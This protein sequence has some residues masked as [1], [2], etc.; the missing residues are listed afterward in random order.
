MLPESVNLMTPF[1]VDQQDI[2]DQLQLIDDKGIS[3]Y[4]EIEKDRRSSKN[5]HEPW[6]DQE[7]YRTM[8]EAELYI[9]LESQQT[10]G[11]KK[12]TRGSKEQ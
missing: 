7:H 6:K 5:T 9:S 11:T 4:V 10:P 2:N 12:H 8:Q 3:N 1:E